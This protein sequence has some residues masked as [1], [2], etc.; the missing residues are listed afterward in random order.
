MEPEKVYNKKTKRYINKNSAHYNKLINNGWTLN[1][2]ELFPP[3]IE[4]LSPTNMKKQSKKTPLKTIGNVFSTNFI[5][6][7]SPNDLLSLY[8]SSKEH[9]QLLN[10]SSAIT[11]L[12]KQYGLDVNTVHF[13][14]W[15]KQ[16]TSTIMPDDLKYLYNMENVR[17][18]DTFVNKDIT[19]DDILKTFEVMYDIRKILKFRTLNSPYAQTLFMILLTKHYVPVEKL[20][21]YGV[22]CI[23]HASVLFEY[24]Q[25]EPSEYRTELNEM[26]INISSEQI[27]NIF[28]EVFHIFDGKLIYPAPVLFIDLK[29]DDVFV[30]TILASMISSIAM[31]KPSLIAETCTYM[32]TGKKTIYSNIEINTICKEIM[33]FLYK[34][35]ETKYI[36]IALRIQVAFDDRINY[37]C[38][39]EDKVLTMS[40]LHYHEPWH[41]GNYKKGKTLGRG[42]FGKVISVKR[43]TCGTDYAV[44]I[45]H[46]EQDINSIY[47]EV[48]ILS[49]LK[50]EKFIINLCGIEQRGDMFDMILPLFDTSLDK[51]SITDEKFLVSVFKQL[52]EA[53][54]NV[55][56][57]DVIH[58]DIKL[59]NIALKGDDVVLIDFGI[60]LPLRRINTDLAPDFANTLHYRPPE[61][62]MG[63]RHYGKGIDIWALGCVFYK[64]VIG[65][66]IVNIK[67][68][69]E[70]SFLLDQCRLFGTPTEKTWPGLS[71]LPQHT[72]LVQYPKNDNV[73]S[74][75][76]VHADLILDCLTMYPGNR[77]TV[78]QL[79]DK[80][81]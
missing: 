57:Y 52:L 81:F 37:A 32:I 28:T 55:H 7:L 2:N 63:D 66:F 60:S 9:Q 27:N 73:R 14:T 41:L 6:H 68:I 62:L 54:K 72:W 49:L 59:E 18:I 77:P 80:Y 10:T 45:T 74:S 15:Y 25:S 23:H 38:G 31:Y 36:N 79:L 51:I 24:M 20:L 76:G 30:L 75:L 34:H 1:K 3:K 33:T 8:L 53:V 69:D 64:L 13:T 29:N 46:P 61:C 26:G 4:V 39:H 17:Y 56:K 78:Q 44:K 43:I 70:K 48:A 47:N 65:D 19:E 5:I 67:D 21:L 71:Q 40:K 58:R 22:A 35:E 50:G 12:N 11:T 16:Y 42:G